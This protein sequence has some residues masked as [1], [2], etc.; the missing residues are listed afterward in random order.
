MRNRLQIP[1][2]AVLLLG[3]PPALAQDTTGKLCEALTQEDA[4]VVAKA[5]A[6]ARL[7]KERAVTLALRRALDRWAKEERANAEVVRLF[8]LDAL[9]EHGAKIP[10]DQLLPM[11]DDPLTEIPALVLLCREPAMNEA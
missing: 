2:L 6:D 3:T 5:A 8:L 4:R 1:W 11:L 10:G 7:V 9:V